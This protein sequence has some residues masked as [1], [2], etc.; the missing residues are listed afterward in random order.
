MKKYLTLTIF[1]LIF[2]SAFTDP[3]RNDK[4]WKYSRTISD[5]KIFHREGVTDGIYEFLAI[6]TI[7]KPADIIL[8]AILD[9]PANRYWMAD[10]IHSE[11]LAGSNS[12]D[13]IA[14]YITAPPWPVSRR[15]TVV[16]IK[17]AEESGT[18]TFTISALPKGDAEKYKPVNNE[19]VR[20]YTM[21]ST[22]TLIETNPGL[23]EVKFSVAGES[24][25]TIPDFMVRLGG[26]TIPYKTLSGLKKFLLPEK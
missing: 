23:T 24:G 18:I 16:I 6:T 3:L 8:K 10:C 26:W 22:V 9:I 14:Y 20:I 12:G 11:L 25:G 2:S 13:K 1:L 21:S 19:N 4:P 17:T 7:N 5:I 15:D